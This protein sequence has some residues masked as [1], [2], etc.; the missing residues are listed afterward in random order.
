MVLKLYGFPKAGHTIT[1]A[2]TLLEKKIPFEM[3]TID[4][5]NGQHKS[6]EYLAIQ[7]LGLVPCIDDDGFILYES[8]AISRYL[9]DK[10]APQ[11]TALLPAA[12]DFNA[13]ALFEQAA[14]VE[15]TAFQQ[16]AHTIY[17]EAIEKP[18]Q[19]FPK[20]QAVWEQGVAQLSATLDVYETTLG[21][22][23]FIAGDAFSLVDLF[24]IAFGRMLAAS[25][26]DLLTTKGPNVARWWKDIMS[27]PSLN[28]LQLG[29][30]VV[31]TLVY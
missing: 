2:V 19:G 12:D 26:C 11:G 14:S 3:V 6:A 27:R 16:H 23:K 9:A 13:K 8:R 18:N 28:N 4:V 15:V 31:S 7:P 5:P 17:V 20:D 30:E 10:Y 24:H 29:D 22:Q 25:G 21:K 1:P